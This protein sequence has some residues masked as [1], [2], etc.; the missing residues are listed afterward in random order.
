MVA[1]C[2]TRLPDTAFIAPTS[3]TGA[4][5]RPGSTGGTATGAGTTAGT[6]ADRTGRTGAAAADGAANPNARVTAGIGGGGGGAGGGSSR[7]NEA[8]DVGITPTTVRLGTIAAEEGVLG[9]AFAPPVWGLRAWVAWI[10]AQGGIGGR[11]V[12]LFTCDDREDRSQ[13][14]QCAH[15]LVEQDKVFALIGVNSRAIGGAAQYLEDHAIPVMGI[16]ITN[17]FN[18]FRHFFSAYGSSYPRDGKQVGYAGRLQYS[19]GDYRFFKSTMGAKRAA[20][21]GY[22]IAESSQALDLFEKGLVL[23]GYTVKKYL[24]SFAAPSFDT[25]VVEMQRDGTQLIVDAMDEGA[26]AH[27]CETMARHQFKP[28]AKLTQIPSFGATAKTAFND[29]CRPTTYVTGGSRPYT[30]TS[31]PFIADFQR[32]MARYQPGRPLHQWELEAWVMADQLRQGLLAMGPAPTAPGLRGLP[33]APGR[34]RRAGRDHRTDPLGG[35]PGRGHGVDGVE[36]L[37][38]RQVGRQEPRRLGVGRRVPLLRGRDP[39]VHQPRG[40]GRHLAAGRVSVL[41]RSTPAGR[42]S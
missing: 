21:F 23:E 17:S 8:S 6:A 24:V 5:G 2:G 14:L 16:P 7:P 10:N 30:A 1:A 20:L 34:R 11:T 27:L 12:Q 4:L 13:S 26:N 37:G 41:T 38:H 3:N 32:A 25:A 39:R 29:T 18:R 15:R 35:R 22:D 31:V 42:A 40:R 9:D 36:L 33:R 28:L 19:S